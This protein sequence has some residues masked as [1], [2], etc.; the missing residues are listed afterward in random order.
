MISTETRVDAAGGVADREPPALLA[1]GVAEPLPLVAEEPSTRVEHDERPSA[2][3]ADGGAGLA[4]GDSPQR[5]E[6]LQVDGR[7]D[8]L[9]DA[10]LRG[11]STV[12]VSPSTS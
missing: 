4:L 2:L 10:L 8:R 6:Q 11:T 12:R 9:P 1:L 7:E 5:L 3:V